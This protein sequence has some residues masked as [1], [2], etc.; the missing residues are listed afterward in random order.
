MAALRWLGRF[1]ALIAGGALALM[2]LIPLLE[3]GLRPLFGRGIDNAPVLVQHLGLVLAMFGALVAERGQ[4]LSS[5]GAGLAAARQPQ[6]RWAARIFAQASAAVLCGML[7][8]TSWTFVASE[9]AA[10]R[11]IAYGIAG[12]M[13]EIAMP[14][15]FALLGCKLAGRLGGPLPVR[16]LLGLLLPA[17]GF[18]FAGHFDG[19]TLPLWPFALWLTAI[20][21]C[22]APIFAVLGGL[23]LALFWSEGQP[24]A[25][26]PLSHYQITVNP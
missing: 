7:T 25:S 16:W 21:F 14:I 4:H 8:Q 9:M 18:A 15:G 1:D 3:I 17:A 22:G 11:D 10:P 5:L 24:L 6:V 26:V 13:V 12:W 19:E 23:A 20:L 2:L